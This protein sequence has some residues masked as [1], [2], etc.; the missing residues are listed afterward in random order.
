M[1]AGEVSHRGQQIK[2]A[3]ESRRMIRRNRSN[4]NL[5]YR[6]PRFDNRRRPEGWFHPSLNSLVE[7][8]LTWT[9]RLCKFAQPQATSTDR[10]RFDIQQLVNPEISGVEYQQGELMGYEVREY[11]LEKWGRK[12]AYLGAKNVPLDIEPINSKSHG[13]SNRVSNLT[14]PCTPCNRA[15]NN[16]TAEELGDPLIQ[17][18]SKQPLKDAAAVNATRWEL[19][20]VLTDLGLPVEVGTG[21]RTNFNRRKQNHAKTHWLDAACVGRTGQQVYASNTMTALAIKAT[22]NERSQMC[23]I[24]R[25]GFPHTSPKLSSVIQGF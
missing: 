13:G 15:K 3:L 6:Q 1:W 17:A 12:Y 24:Y 2:D 14:L 23:L 25:Y 4:R 21:G 22:G 11:L 10:V 20:R 7:I 8:N 5:R 16:Q 18:K 19:W 9:L